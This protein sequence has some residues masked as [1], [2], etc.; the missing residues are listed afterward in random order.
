[1]RKLL[2]LSLTFYAYSL[3]AQH[4][5]GTDKLLKKQ[6]E[7][8]PEMEANF[9][10]QLE[11]IAT[12][13]RRS[14]RAT[15]EVIYVPVVFHIIHNGDAIGTGENISD[16]QCISQIDALN[17][18]FN[19]LD[20]D[21]VNVPQV[22][23]SLVGNARI[24]F[25]LAKFDPTG[26]PT[27]GIERLQYPNA[28]WDEDNVIDATLKPATIWDRTK[29]LNI[30]SV[31]MGGTLASEGVLAYATLPF[32]ATNNNDGIV[33]RFNTIGT[34]GTLLSGIDRGKTVGHE[35]GHWLGL[36]HTWGFGPGCGDQG[37]FIAD[38]PD[39]DDMNFGCPTF[40]RV[41]CT[42]SAPNGDMF[43]NYMD[44]SDD[45]CRNMFSVGQCTRMNDIL[46]SNRA[47]IKQSA[48]KC[49]YNLDAALLELRVPSDTI[50]ALSVKPLV[51]LQNAGITPL[52][53][54]TFQV[55]VDGGVPQVFNWT[56]FLNPQQQTSVVLPQVNFTSGIHTFNVTFTSPN[57]LSNDNFAGNDAITRTVFAYSSGGS[58]AVPFSEDFE[59]ASFPAGSN[60]YTENNDADRTWVL[61][62]SLSAYDNGNYSVSI[63][64]FS[65]TS[66]P[67]KKRDAII[68][69]NYN[70]SNIQY[71]EL[72]FDVAYARL[73]VNRKDSLNI[74][75]SFDCGT[76]WIKLWG[77]DGTGLATAPD[78][79][80]KFYPN[81]NQWQNVTIPVLDLVPQTH[82]SFKFENVTGWGNVLYLDNINVRNNTAL[83]VEE[84]NRFEVGIFPNPANDLLA[85]RLP[86]THP[87]NTI[88]I[89]NA[90][91]EVVHEEAV[92]SHSL[93]FNIDYLPNGMYIARIKG[94]NHVQSNKFFVQR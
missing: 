38:T 66:N 44:Y 81:A 24:N 47:S 26:N 60:W 53:S 73:N 58:S 30:W 51:T 3:T 63:D 18:D 94:G 69:E 78:Q 23:R 87:F 50:C 29:Y 39:Q 34:V 49:F 14:S 80:T 37:D 68:T 84:P 12:E 19:G 56:G 27:S 25:C 79:T 1:M 35:A 64:N 67:N 32:S 28:T 72:S 45:N 20:P 52:T 33:A 59:S 11:E 54:G 48:T 36:L 83:A 65:Y 55:S 16:A 21:V 86:F 8:N 57:G 89:V 13:N 4:W 31:R 75:Y 7:A 77:K 61:E 46:N 88:E 15:Q 17:R 76:R 2:F 43:M 82:V 91:G 22:F 62:T 71:P 70:F 41:S 40:P 93:I 9:M 85:I 10:R 74:Y 42:Q 5:C 92:T 6:F 90:M